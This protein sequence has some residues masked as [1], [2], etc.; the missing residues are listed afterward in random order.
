MIVADIRAVPVGTGTS[1]SRYIKAIHKMLD[2]EGV[3]YLPGPM[4]TAVEV[5]TL[6]ELMGIV[7]LT[8]QVLVDMGVQRMLTTINIDYRLDKEIS[9]ESKI[10]ATEPELKEHIRSK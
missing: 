8:N 7:D 3:S 5:E 2:D 1:L 4:S 6:D 9:I 10:E